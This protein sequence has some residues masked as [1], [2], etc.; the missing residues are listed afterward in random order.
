MTEINNDLSVE[1]VCPY[2]LKLCFIY[3]KASLKL[4]REGGNNAEE[5]K[6]IFK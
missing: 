3:G 6:F 1:I 4:F 5:A 2:S